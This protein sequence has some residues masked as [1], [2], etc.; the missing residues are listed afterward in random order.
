MGVA[1][2]AALAARSRH[3]TRNG[4]ARMKTSD[5]DS[6]E[7]LS[8]NLTPFGG[9]EVASRMPNSASRIWEGLM[10]CRDFVERRMG[11]GCWWSSG[12]GLVAVS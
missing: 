12:R 7:S 10:A 2:K 1:A 5:H 4:S 8:D 6:N 11:I 9:V 3:V